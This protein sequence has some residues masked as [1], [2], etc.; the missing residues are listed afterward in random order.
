[1]TNIDLIQPRH[2][3]AP[4][5]TE[6]KLGHIY[7]PT[8][9]YTEASRLL[10]AGVDVAVHDENIEPSQISSKYVGINLLGAPY[11]PEAIKLQKRIEE[12]TSERKAFLL[13]GQVISGLGEQQLKRLFGENSYNG[14][15]DENLKRILEIPNRKLVPANMTSLIDVYKRIPDE[16]MKEYL[17]REFSLYVSN[18][19]LYNC[20]FCGVFERTR[21][22]G[23]GNKIK[24]GETY[25]EP[26]IIG[27]DLDYLTRRAKKLGINNFS[28]YMSNLDVFQNPEQLLKFAYEVQ[29]V[30]K[31]HSGFKIKLRGLST[32]TSFLEARKKNP[33]SI[34]QIIAAGFDTVGFGIDGFGQ[35]IWNAVHKSH[36]TESKCF[37]AIKCARESGITPE[38]LMVFGHPKADNNES[39]EAAL[40]FTEKM[41][42]DYGAIPRPHVD[43]SFIPGNDDWANPPNEATRQSIERLMQHPELF[44]SLD[45]TALPT[46]LSHPNPK[47]RELT[48]DYFLKMCELKGNTT[49]FV[50]PITPDLTPRQI[51]EV[52]KFN[53]ERYDR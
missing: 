33:N 43:K 46:S 8:S 23:M 38:I 29:K 11:I 1:M 9:L 17:S 19:C 13:G 24:A 39:L 49:Q 47:L 2:N 5:I 10:S 18:G 12:E 44:Q 36:N 35:E 32:V 3:C 52:K 6:E 27:Q 40:K 7:M 51:E 53:E 22:D 31:S 34:E 28:I 41:I 4:P 50:K 42:E 26:Q 15:L 25:R 20:S 45:F 14:N 30:K 37:D 48:T 21:Q 16:V